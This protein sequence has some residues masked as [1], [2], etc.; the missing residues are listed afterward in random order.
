M[1]TSPHALKFERN[2]ADCEP[3]L[4]V[5]GV[6]MGSEDLPLQIGWLLEHE[7]DVEIQDATTPGMLDGDWQQTAD[8]INSLLAGYPGRIGIHAPFWDINLMAR[9]PRVRTVVI[10][11]LLESVRFAE[12]IGATHMVAHSPFNFFGNP[13]LVH[14]PANGLDE[15]IAIVQETLAPV[16]PRL[17]RMGGTLVI[18]T[19]YDRHPRPLLSLVD[20]IDSDSVR[21][22]LDVGHA[23]IS[24]LQGGPTPDEWVREV[25][26][27]LAHVH[28][29]DTDGHL[30][31]HW[32]PGQGNVNWFALFEALAALDEM[33]R[34]IVEMRES[35]DIK[36]AVQWLSDQGFAL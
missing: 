27:L 14:S 24:H 9:D 15:E 18:E 4:P 28:L 8:Y 19:I 3:I 23:Y 34:L 13:H 32:P 21:L 36:P 33:P 25:G 20:A 5:A 22:S 10:S 17:E 26:S 2:G 11:R 31:R 1:I 29:Q 35:S 6:A 30:D 16:L 12:A 7:R